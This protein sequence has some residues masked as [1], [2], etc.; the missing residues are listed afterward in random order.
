[1]LQ[2]SLI[3][4]LRFNLKYAEELIR[5][6]PENILSENA[7]PGLENHAI[8]TLGHLVTALGLTIKYLNGTYDISPEWDDLFRRKGPGDPRLPES[9]L[10]KYPTSS[11]LLKVLTDKTNQLNL[12]IEHLPDEELKKP[13]VWRFASHFPTLG[14]LLSFMIVSH[15]SMH[16]GQLA[17]W[18]RAKGFSSAL[19]KL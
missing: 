7:G 1:M 2:Q 18:R 5:D 14:D 10:Q 3:H 12:L 11:E 13:V 19:A 6:I 16:L 4:S 8:F 9:D 15:T 17:A